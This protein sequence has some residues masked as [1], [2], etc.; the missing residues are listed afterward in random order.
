MLERVGPLLVAVALPEALRVLMYAVMRGL[1]SPAYLIAVPDQFPAAISWLLTAIV[2]GE[3]V[4]YVAE[5]K[6]VRVIPQFRPWP[7]WLIMAG[8]L[9]VTGMAM[10]AVSDTRLHLSLYAGST[11]SVDE[12]DYPQIATIG[13]A[14]FALCVIIRGLVY[15]LAGSLVLSERIS[16][17]W[18]IRW[19]VRRSP[20]LVILSLIIL[21]ALE[22]FSK[23]WWFAYDALGGSSAGNA[24]GSFI[25]EFGRSLIYQL[26]EIPVDIVFDVLP[27]VTIGLIWRNLRGR[28]ASA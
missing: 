24:M 7:T 10:N 20:S 19:V 13:W 27:A 16:L 28:P 25:A 2:F 18:T 15:P 22:G 3:V 5:D 11:G 14:A 21:S 26:P 9:V 8:I 6:P 17:A 4:R 1:E 23:L 12:R